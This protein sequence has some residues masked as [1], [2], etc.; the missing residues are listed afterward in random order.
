ML[1]KTRET[2]PE[3]EFLRA[4]ASL[5]AFLK[6]LKAEFGRQA[7]PLIAALRDGH[8]HDLLGEATDLVWDT[9]ENS[10]DVLVTF[11]AAGG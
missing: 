11:T 5:P 2:L 6:P 8:D 3:I 1:D 7:K 4:A 9:F 10:C